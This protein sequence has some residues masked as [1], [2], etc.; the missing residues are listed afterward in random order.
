MINLKTRY[1]AVICAA[2]M[3]AS[4]ETINS[5]SGEGIEKSSSASSQASQE[6]RLPAQTLAPG[7]CGLF[8]FRRDDARSF[9]LFAREGAGAKLFDGQERILSQTDKS[10]TPY[11]LQYPVQSFVTDQ[12]MR[13]DLT[14]SDPQVLDQGTR[15]TNGLLEQTLPDGW[16]LKMPVAAL[17]ICLPRS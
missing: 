15:Y 16:S 6:S 5:V 13:V 8:V 4:C 3:M 10:G 9:T 7:E 2:M 1:S 12:G 17:S 14:L 11:D